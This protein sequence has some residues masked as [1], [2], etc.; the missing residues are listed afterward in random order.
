M[1]S[2]RLLA[3]A[4][5]RLALLL[6][7]T[8]LQSPAH[9]QADA[10]HP[11]LPVIDVARS[12][13]KQLSPGNGWALLQEHLYWTHDD[14]A[15][16]MDIT[17][18]GAVTQR[19]RDVFFL[20]DR[21]GW[22]TL[23]D[24]GS[25]P[26]AGSPILQLASTSDGGNAWKV[27]TFDV[28]T[29]PRFVSGIGRISTFFLNPRL[30]WILLQPPS[31]SNFSLAFLLASEDGG[32]TWAKLPPPPGA[33]SIHFLTSLD[34]WLA[35]GVGGYQ[36][37]VTHDG[38][39]TWLQKTAPLPA[40]CQACRIIYDLPVFT[41]PL[42]G[43]LLTNID[44]PDGDKTA[45]YVSHDG[46]DSWELTELNPGWGPASVVD[47]HVIQVLSDG[48]HRMAVRSAGHL[49]TVTPPPALGV[50]ANTIKVDFADDSH[51]WVLS[52][53]HGCAPGA[54]T[55]CKQLVNQTAQVELL[56][57]A[58]GGSTFRL[59]TPRP[60]LKP[61]SQNRLRPGHLFVSSHDVN[62]LSRRQE[63]SSPA[64]S[65]SSKLNL[66]SFVTDNGRFKPKS[67]EARTPS[68][69]QSTDTARSTSAKLT[70]RSFPAALSVRDPKTTVPRHLPL[71]D[72]V[73][74]GSYGLNTEIS[75]LYAGFDL[76]CVP[77]IPKMQTWWNWSPFYDIGV[78]LG[79]SN[80]TC[81]NVSNSWSAQ[82]NLMG[83][84]IMPLW[85]GPQALCSNR[86]SKIDPANAYVQGAAEAS[87]AAAAADANSLY[88][89]II[90]YDM[91]Q[92]PPG[93]SFS[94]EVTSFLSGWTAQLHNLGFASGVYSSASSFGSIVQASPLADVAWIA[95]WDGPPLSF[96]YPRR[97][98][99]VLEQL[100]PKSTPVRWR[101]TASLERRQRR[102]HSRPR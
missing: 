89:S 30:G 97:T 14:G 71:P 42:N 19:I 29:D 99:P 12:A 53:S 64:F 72:F 18:P 44:A 60:S 74:Q 75:A 70:R 15:T 76:A 102:Q 86:P 33:G 50:R 17:P 51:G 28:A 37:W 1:R 46:G 48:Q 21:N 11:P 16:W 10:T 32:R 22:A 98:R 57:T 3:Q 78:Y 39:R 84:G 62:E 61:Q 2:Q 77:T 81:H 93:G 80:A 73:L 101:G 20:D 31:S 8:F 55:P 36:L 100:W 5:L 4:L 13:M 67:L 91:E 34:G 7:C 6:S 27:R 94:S 54:P 58:D 26:S 23:A 63:S 35:G 45:T 24:Y 43:V 95:K 49:R 47:F 65:L 82:A 96:Q 90:Y 83:W 88:V 69:F 41:D 38:G 59:I 87:S 52:V 25:L 56:S 66:A 68:Y 9:G 40:D 92:C 85:V 79:G